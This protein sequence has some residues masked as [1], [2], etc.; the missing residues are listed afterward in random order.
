MKNRISSTASN[1]KTKAKARLCMSGEIKSAVETLNQLARPDFALARDK[2][3]RI[4]LKILQRAQG[5]AFMTEVKAG[6]LF[7]GKGGSG[8]VIRKQTDGTW[9]GPCAFGFAGVGAGL[10]VG[11]SKTSTIVVLNTPEA[12]DVFTSKGQVKFGA[13]LEVT[14]GPVGRD[15]GGELRGGKTGIAPCFS[16][17]H[18]KGLYAGL[19]IDGTCLITKDN[20]NNEFYGVPVTPLEILSK[21]V[22]PPAELYELNELYT[23]LA[24]LSK[25]SVDD[26][27]KSVVASATSA[28]KGAAVKAALTK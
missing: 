25:V 12:C 14:A 16:Y 17:S 6:F 24:R 2:E 19:S 9:S 5:L 7:S 13:D 21:G 26:V 28:V 20:V 27:A 15:I 1:L 3:Q 8:I 10:M 18:S 23:I 4:P 11:A 22:E